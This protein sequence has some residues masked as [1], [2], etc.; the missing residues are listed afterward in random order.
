M[1]IFGKYGLTGDGSKKFFSINPIS[2]K[3]EAANQLKTDIV[4]KSIK[5]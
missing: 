5:S 3:A 1:F 4:V 2:T